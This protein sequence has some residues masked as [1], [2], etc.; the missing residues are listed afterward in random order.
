[1]FTEGGADPLL[2]EY[3]PC[4]DSKQDEREGY[5]VSC[6]FRAVLRRLFAW[7]SSTPARGL[8]YGLGS[9]ICGNCPCM[10]M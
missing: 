8:N 1:M 10:P 3:L 9:M 4:T 6:R 2:Q 7:G 5:V